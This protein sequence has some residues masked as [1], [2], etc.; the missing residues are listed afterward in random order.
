MLQSIRNRSQGWIAWVIVILITIPFALWGVHEYTGGAEETPVAKVA[1]GTIDQRE[2]QRSYNQQRTRLRELMG[3]AY[4]SQVDETELR[5]EVLEQLVNERVIRLATRDAGFRLG[6]QELAQRIRSFG[7]FRDGDDFS[8]ARYRQALQAQGM[9]PGQFEDIL[10]RDLLIEQFEMAVRTTAFATEHEVERHL[11]LAEQRREVGFGRV[12]PEAFMEP[13]AIS[14]EAIEEYYEAHRDEFHEPERVALAYVTLSREDL[15]E[16]VDVSEDE[17]RAEYEHNPAAFGGDPGRREASHILFLPE[18]EGEAAWDEA[19]EEA[20]AVLDELESGA[21][22]AELAAE[23]SDDP[24]SAEEGGSLGWF[25]REEMDE[26]LADAAFDM[27]ETGQIE[28][29][30]RSEFGYHIV[31]LDGIEE[32]ADAPDFEEVRDE[33]RRDIQ[34]ARAESLFFEESE[35]LANLAYE[36][37]DTL[38]LAAEAVDRP[39]ETTEA[40]DRDGLENGIASRSRVI[41]AAFSDEVLEERYNSPLLEFD[42]DEVAVV[43]VREHHPAEQLPLEAVDDRVRT[44]LARERA[45]ERAH[46]EAEA[47]AERLRAGEAEPGALLDD[48]ESPRTISRRDP[49]LPSAV[50]RAAFRMAEGEEP[51]YRVVDIGNSGFAVVGLY[52]VLETDP[53]DVPGEQRQQVR[54]QMTQAL[55]RGDYRQAVQALR[56]NTDITINLDN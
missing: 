28:G 21:D 25:E 3:D 18:G 11:A 30:V 12:D 38:E 26:A 46:E 14:D 9:Q 32:D 16:R 4:D 34:R 37:P 27:E 13:E 53:E 22:F 47:I 43:R 48:W 7:A 56:D 20:E 10:R 39:V 36:H 52:D 41:E 33:V 19:R 44:I 45:T 35:R 29:P 50:S 40:F 55:A 2:F 23:H 15:S 6:D 8:E 54:G 17:V 49:G 1:D 31:R 5:R 42:D 24:G 51:S